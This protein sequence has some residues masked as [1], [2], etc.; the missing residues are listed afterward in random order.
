MSKLF[1]GGLRVG[2][3]RGP[4]E[5]IAHL[6]QVKATDDL[7]SSVISQLATVRLLGQA[8]KA[9]ELRRAEV[10]TSLARLEQLM[11][12]YLPS[13]T[14]RPPAGGLSLWACLPQGSASELA[15]AAMRQ[16][17]AIVPGSVMSPRGAFDDHVRLPLGRGDQTMTAAIKALAEAWTEYCASVPIRDAALRVVV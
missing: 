14:W 13:W 15:R 10:S 11:R 1:W 16:G 12:Q 17:L 6:G 2:W 3:I 8:L 9:R 7:G 4:K 5:M